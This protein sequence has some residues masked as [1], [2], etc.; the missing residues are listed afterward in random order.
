VLIVGIADNA[1]YTIET[2]SRG[3]KRG[4]DVDW[5]K[6]RKREANCATNCVNNIKRIKYYKKCTIIHFT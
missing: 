1:M 2:R 4:G 5:I 6:T 3:E